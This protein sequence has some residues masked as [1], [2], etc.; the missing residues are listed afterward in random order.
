MNVYNFNLR[1][2][3]VFFIKIVLSANLFT[4]CRIGLYMILF[5]ITLLFL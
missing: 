4:F 3:Y 5:S 2:E 1:I